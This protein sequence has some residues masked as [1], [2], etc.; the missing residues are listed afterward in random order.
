TKNEIRIEDEKRIL[1]FSDKGVLERASK[2]NG[3]ALDN[4]WETVIFNEKVLVFGKDGSIRKNGVSKISLSGWD[5]KEQPALV[6]YSLE[7]G[8]TYSG[9]KMIDGKKY[10]FKDGAHYTFDGHETIDG[11]RYYFNHDGEAK[12][13]GFDKVDGKIYYYND[14]GEMQTGWQEIDG[15]SY[16]F[17][18]SGAAKI[19]W[20]QVGGGYHFPNYG[21]FTYYAKQDGSIYTDT[22]VEIDGKTYTFD[23]HGHKGY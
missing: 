5:G 10:H 2:F 1:H 17:D 9:W 22:K 13:T 12:L 7:E 3:E 6:Y 8:A 15:K 16:Y 4:N 19:G 23:S 20:F 21:Y 14:K 18:E 11:K